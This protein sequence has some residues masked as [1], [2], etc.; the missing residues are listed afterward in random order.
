MNHL[1]EITRQLKMYWAETCMVRRVTKICKEKPKP[2][3]IIY[4]YRGTI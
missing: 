1:K 3:T 4:H 2:K